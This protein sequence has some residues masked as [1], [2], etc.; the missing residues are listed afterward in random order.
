MEFAGNFVRA[1][2]GRENFKKL[3]EP[4]ANGET[5]STEYIS[6]IIGYK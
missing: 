5:I 4:L 1:K 6:K 2:I 3:Y